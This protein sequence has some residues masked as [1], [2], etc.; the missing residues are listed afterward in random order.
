VAVSLVSRNC[1]LLDAA[2]VI[3]AAHAAGA[4]V[5][6]DAYQAVGV[7]PIDVEALGVDVLVGGMH[8]WLSGSTGLAF[9]YV[10]PSLSERLEPAYPGWI[11]HAAFNEFVH[12]KVFGDAYVKPAG[13]RRFQQGTP[14]M[15]A[16]YSSR[17]GLRFVLEAG[18]GQIRARNNELTTYLY[19]GALA[20]GF[21]V[22]TPRAANERAGGICIEVKDPQAIVQAMAARGIDV[23]ER[24]GTV[25]R[26]GLHPCVTREECDLFL[27]VLEE[28]MRRRRFL[29]HIQELSPHTRR[30]P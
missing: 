15:A 16:V 18:P 29:R 9:L 25:L 12:T 22:R 11:G 6:L 13:A 23:D 27:Q 8:K 19:E 4:I 5:V 1:A 21:P 17:A 28:L 24:Y 26:A 2:P 3:A 30:T 10:R 14:A 7:L 20:L